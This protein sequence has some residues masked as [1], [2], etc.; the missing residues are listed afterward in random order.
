VEFLRS[1][2][3]DLQHELGRALVAALWNNPGHPY[4]IQL[5]A[6]E[7]FAIEQDA[8]ILSAE[9]TV[10]ETTL[11]KVPLEYHIPVFDAPLQ[12]IPHFRY[13]PADWVCSKCGVC[14]AKKSYD[15]NGGSTSICQQSRSASII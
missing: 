2:I 12:R 4:L 14:C 6:H 5:D 13:F 3:Q 11:E 8:K 15:R 1:R 9:A 7:H 10:L